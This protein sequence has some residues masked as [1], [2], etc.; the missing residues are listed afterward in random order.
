MKSKVFNP[1]PV[2]SIGRTFSP[3]GEE[4]EQESPSL[5][6]D[7]V[8][9]VPRGV[10]DFAHSVYNLAD[11]FSYDTLP[12]WDE[13]RLLGHSKTW[14]GELTNGITQF[15]TGFIPA[16][17]VAGKVSKLG[18]LANVSKVAPTVAKYSKFAAA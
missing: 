9:G 5:I 15:A 11:Y 8:L 13:Q 12:D 16:L 3:M 14:A 7:A 4:E 18:R 10:E 17:G 1:T 6:A 2:T